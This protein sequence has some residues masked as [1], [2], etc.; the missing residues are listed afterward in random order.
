MKKL[1]AALLAFFCLHLF[2]VPTRAATQPPL[3]SCQSPAGDVIAS[4]DNGT[5][6]IPGDYGTY[7]GS[8]KVYRVTDENV[9][10]CYCPNEGGSGIQSNWWK[11]P[12][13]SSEEI[14]YFQKLGWV[15]IPNGNAWGLAD[16]PYLV[17]NENFSC[18]GEGGTGGTGGGS[19]SSSDNSS[20]NSSSSNDSNGIGGAVLGAA[21]ADTG[22]V[23]YVLLFALGTCICSLIAY[24]V[25]RE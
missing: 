18:G 17:K 6:G 11:I 1:S 21:L 23:R 13:L 5:H 25:W 8:D 10:Q 15:Y 22:N 7:T 4:Y 19:S 16:A 14:E 12:Q 20:S 24:R 9:L 3:F 2:A